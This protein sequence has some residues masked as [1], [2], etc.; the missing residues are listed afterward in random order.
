MVQSL[1]FSDV[2]I[3]LDNL[4]EL[5]FR[6][7]REQLTD[8]LAGKPADREAAITVGRGYDHEVSCACRVCLTGHTW[9]LEN[10]RPCLYR[11]GH[12][13]HVET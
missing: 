3:E 13:I 8:F 7:A 1:A 9:I 11:E 4:E 6:S 5:A 2:V 10:R 12:G